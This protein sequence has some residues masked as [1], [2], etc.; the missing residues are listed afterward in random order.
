MSLIALGGKWRV[1]MS[2]KKRDHIPT[3]KV[4]TLGSLPFN[5]VIHFFFFS[6]TQHQMEV[7][8]ISQVCQLAL[9]ICGYWPVPLKKKSSYISW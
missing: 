8:L 7:D 6:R 4:H 9:L 2:W 5:T 1:K 3:I